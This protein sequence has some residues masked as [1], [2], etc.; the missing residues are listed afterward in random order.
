MLRLS[1]C[2]RAAAAF[3]AAALVLLAPACGGDGDDE[4]TATP[5][6]TEEGTPPPDSAGP[7]SGDVIDL[8]SQAPLLTVLGEND[9]DFS[10]GSHSLAIG[11]FNDDGD[12]DM[13]V[14]APLADGPE[15]AR[16]EGG[17]AYVF[18]GPLEGEVDLEDGEPGVT[19][20]GALPGDNLGYSVLSGD[21]NGDG[22]DDILV[23]APGVT[24][25]FDPRTDQGRVYVFFGGGDLQ[26]E[27]D[28]SGDV[29][30]FTVTGAEG[31]SRLGHAMDMGDVNG[32]GTSDL[33]TG[34]PFAGRAAGS[35]PGSAR[36]GVGEVY[37]FYGSG[38][39]SGEKNV[40]SLHQDVLIS[41]K[42]GEPSF[43]EFG[44]SLTVADFDSDGT[45]D[46]AV[47]AHRSDAG[48]DRA[49]SGVVYVF[50]GRDDWPDRVTTEADEQNVTILGPSAS[51]GFGL[52]LTSGDFD[53][54]GNEDLAAGSRT[55]A[56]EGGP[57]SGAV[58]VIFGRSGF[59]GTIDLREDEATVVLPG[60]HPGSLLPASLSAADIDGDSDS[61]LVAGAPFS[62]HDEGRR[63]A[64]LVY[65]IAGGTDFEDS[66]NL[67][68]R[69]PLLGAEIDDQLGVV[70]LATRY[71]DEAGGVAALATGVSAGE[72]RE[73]AGAVYLIPITLQ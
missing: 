20:Y 33:V 66:A 48:T 41:G 22:T 46:I 31:F 36:T 25:G 27:Y 13:L 39:L 24:A 8:A 69:R 15:E 17:E 68:D 70:A 6:A 19:I 10:T 18:F 29:Y 47:G 59:G 42:Q 28:L 37:I 9:D 71:S 57:S 73:Q 45:D 67:A 55:E 72:G 4:P 65:V 63:S 62:G 53:A 56:A 34:A 21:L 58:R 61:E 1:A 35:P 43:G 30:D 52:P 16:A 44:A 3:I 7:I 14:G 60:R 54:D 40:A 11:D 2:S 12:A 50:T 5:T 38:D 23:A 64:G 26:N 51:A 32:D 49:A